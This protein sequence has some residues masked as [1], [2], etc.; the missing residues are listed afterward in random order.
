M[1]E[2]SIK[3]IGP[4]SINIAWSYPPVELRNHVHYFKLLMTKN[5]LKKEAVVNAD[6]Y[7][8]YAFTSLQS[9]STYNFQVSY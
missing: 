8:I 6:S 1:P 9:A 5:D 3:G 7:L 4:S 2:V